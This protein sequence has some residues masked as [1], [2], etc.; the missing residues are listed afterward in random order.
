MNF[1]YIKNECDKCKEDEINDEFNRIYK[2]KC[3]NDEI[4]NFEKKCEIHYLI[5]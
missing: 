4:Y 1:N 5:V 2:S 3:E